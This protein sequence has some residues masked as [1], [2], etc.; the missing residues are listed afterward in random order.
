[1][2]LPMILSFPLVANSFLNLQRSVY[3]K[4]LNFLLYPIIEFLLFPKLGGRSICNHEFL[5]MLF[6]LAV[7]L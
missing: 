1:M 3:P 5:P 2:S 7:L 4:L 6:G